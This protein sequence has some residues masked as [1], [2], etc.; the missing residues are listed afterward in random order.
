MVSP[1][2]NYPIG[3]SEPYGVSDVVIND[4]GEGYL[5]IDTA[6]DNFGTQYELT[7]DSGRIISAKPI[8]SQVISD[9]PTIEVIS[10]TGEGALLRPVLRVFDPQI[11]VK[12]VIDCIT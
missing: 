7:V 10:D 9:I 1:G 2:E 4:P 6:V 11:E 3:D 12:Q 5:P 8:N